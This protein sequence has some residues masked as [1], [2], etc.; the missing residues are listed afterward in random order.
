[1]AV[2]GDLDPAA[3]ARVDE[4]FDQVN[5][6]TETVR[7]V[8][9]H[10]AV[11]DVQ[12]LAERLEQ[13]FSRAALDEA[14]F[15]PVPR[16]GLI[17]LGMLSL[18][19]GLRH[20]QLGSPPDDHER[21]VVLVDDC[22]L[23]GHRIHQ[24]LQATRDQRVALAF[25][26]APIELCRNIESRE[27]RVQGCVAARRLRDIG[28]ELFGTGYGAW[29]DHWAGR[30]GENRYWIGRPEAVSFAW[31]DPDRSFINRATRQREAAWRVMPCNLTP[32]PDRSGDNSLQ[33]QIQPAAK[34]PLQPVDEVF[35]ASINGT[36]VLAHID[37][38][39]AIELSTVAGDFWCAIIESTSV[40]EAVDRLHESYDTDRARLETD[41]GQFVDELLARGLLERA[42]P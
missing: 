28:P 39:A 38:M 14:I 26:Y 40:S 31:K 2:V 21:L 16:G 6:A 10:Q 9:Y 33:M 8:S 29:V 37:H 20:E 34:G 11:I 13:R 12:A 15:R 18:V 35:F 30:V 19:M 25:L 27:D 32:P 42:H 22:A 36:V 23:S 7:Y 4:L 3:V 1:M 41:F 24:T 5:E 17:V